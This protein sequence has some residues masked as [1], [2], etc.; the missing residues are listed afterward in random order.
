MNK[1]TKLIL[2][3]SLFVLIFGGLLTIAT[4]YDYQ[5]SELL[6]SKGM[7]DG[8]YFSRN[9]FGRIFEVIGEMP[10]YL[11]VIVASLMVVINLEKVNNKK[12][13]IP[14]IIL[15]LVVGFGIGIYGWIQFGEYLAELHPDTL[16]FLDGHIITTIAMVIL[17]AVVEVT[18][19]YFMNKYFKELSYKLLPF[20][21]IVLI[22]AAL[23]NGFVQ[24]IKP[25]VARERF[26]AI[27]V[28]NYNY[29]E[30]AHNGFTNWYVFNGPSS[31]IVAALKEAGVTDAK[32][33][34]YSSFPSGHTC[35]ASITYSLMFI[36]FFN[37]KANSKKYKW[38]FVVTPILYTGTV[39]VS[40]I[41]VGAHYMSDVL[42]GGTVGFLSAL[43]GYIIVKA[44]YKK[45]N[46]QF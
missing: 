32:S 3:I 33:T 7:H 9:V 24:G 21:I 4:F 23:S 17:S 28:L 40:R 8:Q 11:F 5:I 35:G 46:K 22:C 45:L 20:A 6:A 2:F 16:G 13:R 37:Q 44:I 14:L 36:P 42:V 26:R 43:I 30:V 1:K 34:Y 18:L 29:P 19:Y 41:V 38:I 10:L 39:A 12:V 15:F 25:I 27:Y 31:K